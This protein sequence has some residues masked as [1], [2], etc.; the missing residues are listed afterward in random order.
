M[1]VTPLAKHDALA[2]IS[3]RFLSGLVGKL[4]HKSLFEGEGTLAEIFGKI[5]IPNLMIREVRNTSWNVLLTTSQQM[6]NSIMHRLTRKDLKTIHRNSFSPIWKT[7]TPNP[8]ANAPKSYFVQCAVS[9]NNKPL[10][11]AVSMSIR[12]LANS[13][14]T[15]VNGK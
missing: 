6:L 3:I 1:N 7:L 4:M 11:S 9:L 5:V 10:L 12:C 13:P 8:D 15:R 14:R 2:T